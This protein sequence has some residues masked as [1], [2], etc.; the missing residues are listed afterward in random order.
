MKTIPGK[1]FFNLLKSNKVNHKIERFEDKHGNITSDND[2]IERMIVDELMNTFKEKKDENIEDKIEM[3][4][5][6]CLDECVKLPKINDEK[7]VLNKEFKEENIEYAIKELN[8]SSAGGSDNIT[9]RSV[10]NLFDKI[11]K[12]VSKIIRKISTQN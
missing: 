7:I 9:T 1:K 5:K 4:S 3:I 6:F 8:S 2:K 11:P 12:T 10:K